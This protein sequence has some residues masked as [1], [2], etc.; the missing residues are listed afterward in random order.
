MFY[1]YIFHLNR[2]PERGISPSAAFESD[3]LECKETGDYFRK[4]VQAKFVTVSLQNAF[5]KVGAESRAAMES[6]ARSACVSVPL[7]SRI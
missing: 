5:H 2:S 1:M 7:L 6:T 3:S 4:S